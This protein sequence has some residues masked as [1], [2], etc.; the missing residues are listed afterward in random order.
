MAP[1]RLRIFSFFLLIGF[2]CTNPLLSGAPA[3]LRIRADSWM[4]FNGD[5]VGEKPG[6]VVELL[7]EI[8]EPRG[9]K[10]DYQIMPWAAAVKAAETGEIDGIIGANR[11]EAAKLVVGRESIAEPKFA[12]FVRAAASWKYESLRSLQGVKL[13]AIEGYNYW[14]SLDDYLRKAPP[15]AIKLYSGD[16]PLIGAL[17]DLSSGKID[18][19]V[20][21]VVVF[22]WAA[23]STGAAAKDFRMAYS[24]Q[25]DPLYVAFSATANGRKAAQAFDEGLRELKRNGRL[26]AIL[27]KYGLSN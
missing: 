23:K 20:E 27:D 15:A 11:K 25:T 13:G 16:T 2:V 1:S 14:E 4:P 6:Y 12:L 19:L 8:F 24:Q 26:A 5:P 22:Y 18:V 10:I 9:V 3:V 21:S 7:R 17:A